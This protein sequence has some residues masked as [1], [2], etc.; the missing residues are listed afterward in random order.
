MAQQQ[1]SSFIGLAKK[2]LRDQKYQH[3]NHV[4]Y[5]PCRVVNSKWFQ[6]W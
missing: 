5:R 6:N 4:M 1:R 2:D 3:L